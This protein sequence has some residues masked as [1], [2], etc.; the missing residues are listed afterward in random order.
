[1]AAVD[2]T[3]AMLIDGEWVAAA[4]GETFSCV[5]PY[6]EETWGSVPRADA[7]DVDR[8]VRAARR[9]F[10]TGGWPRTPPARRS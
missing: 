10:D 3:F 6:T 7:S 8:A 9:A 4:S 2:S 5:N 1:M